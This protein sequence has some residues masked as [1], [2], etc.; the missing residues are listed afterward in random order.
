M[1]YVNGISAFNNLEFNVSHLSSGNL[2]ID[3]IILDKSDIGGAFGI[4]PP[5]ASIV[6]TP[7]VGA[8]VSVF[9]GWTWAEAVGELADF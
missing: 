4:I 2:T 9:T 5:S 8:D 3:E 1:N 7:T 6:T